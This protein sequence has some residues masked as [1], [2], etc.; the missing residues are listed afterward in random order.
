M[1]IKRGKSLIAFVLVIAMLLTAIPIRN[2]V[3]AAENGSITLTFDRFES[4]NLHFKRQPTKRCTLEW[5][6]MDME[7]E[8][9]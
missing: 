1:N 8:T 6:P 7:K 3:M 9:G 5:L 4:N 2:R